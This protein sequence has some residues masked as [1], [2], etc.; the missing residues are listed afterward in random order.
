M[1][2]K[3]AAV[4]PQPGFGGK[5]DEGKTGERKMEEWD[6]NCLQLNVWIPAGEKPKE[7]WPVCVFLHGGKSRLL[8]C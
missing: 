3:G 8:L 1:F 7:G 4:C 2:T 6:E 5:V